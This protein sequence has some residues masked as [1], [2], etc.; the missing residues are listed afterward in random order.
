MENY[1]VFSVTATTLA[2]DAAGDVTIIPLNEIA[3]F[4]QITYERFYVKDTSNNE[5]EF[6]YRETVYPSQDALIGYVSEYF[7][8]IKLFIFDTDVTLAANSDTKAPTQ[9]AAKTYI[10]AKNATNTPFTPYDDITATDTQTAIQQ[11]SNR[12]NPSKNWEW[13]TDWEGAGNSGAT[14]SSDRACL[15]LT[16]TAAGA[17][18]ISVA[19][20]ANR[21]GVYG[22]T[23]GTTSTGGAYIGT[24]P[25]AVLLGGGA[26]TIEHSI[27]FPVLSDN[28]QTFVSRIGSAPAMGGN[29]ANGVFFRYTDGVNSGKFECVCR[30]AGSEAG[31][32]VD[33]GITVAATTWYKLR[34]EINAGATSVDY[35]IDNV[36]V[37]NNTANIPTA[38][39]GVTSQINKTLGNT[40]R[41]IYVDWSSATKIFTTPR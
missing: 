3:E 16:G 36:L 2:Y 40:A 35:Y 26:V 39:I 9:K 38:A 23:T 11:L 8:G 20:L 22:V 5:G 21:I 15:D 27:Y 6:H 18:P 29:P 14:I 34:I 13:Y 25:T 32:V 17:A 28:V 41:L 7:T 4:N 10:D 31:S 24:G 19:A 30:A 37:G 12:W 33:S 1:I